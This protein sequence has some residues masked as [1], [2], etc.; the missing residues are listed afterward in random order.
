MSRFKFENDKRQRNPVGAAILQQKLIFMAANQ[1]AIHCGCA[2][3]G[4]RLV[5]SGKPYAGARVL[6]P[7]GKSQT[8]AVGT[9]LCGECQTWLKMQ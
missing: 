2:R 8:T 3:C 5:K 1:V 6:Y 4:R 9:A 7:R